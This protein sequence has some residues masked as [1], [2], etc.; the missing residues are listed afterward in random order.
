MTTPECQLFNLPLV[1]RIVTISHK[2]DNGCVISKLQELDSRI[3][4]GAVVLVKGEEQRERGE[5]NLGST[6]A[7]PEMGEFRGQN[8]WNDCVEY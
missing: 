4:G 1:Y 2:T 6:S 8:F 5:D 7:L 3:A